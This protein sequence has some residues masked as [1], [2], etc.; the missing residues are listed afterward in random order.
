MFMDCIWVKATEKTE[1][2]RK[3]NPQEHGAKAM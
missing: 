3:A 2:V 1:K